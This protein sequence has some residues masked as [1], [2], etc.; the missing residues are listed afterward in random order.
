VEPSLSTRV[1]VVA[2][3]TA[4]TPWL[5]QE[6][7]RRRGSEFA[8]IVPAFARRGGSDWTADDAA[9]R[10]E[11]AAG[12]RVERLAGDSFA[13]LARA[14]DEGRFD[15]ILVSVMPGRR[16]PRRDLVRRI[17]ALGVP[18]TAI[19]PGARPAIDQTVIKVHWAD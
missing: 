9:R 14:V 5:L 6:I 4:A 16:W 7:E 3:R 11:Q 2:N 17:D 1:L 8:L 10:V 15:E 13:A 18:V 19:T 12:G